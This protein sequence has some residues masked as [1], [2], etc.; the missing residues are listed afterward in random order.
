MS[1]P[2]PEELLA[3]AAE[4]ATAAATLLAQEGAQQRPEVADT[5]P[6]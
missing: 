2:D 4:T 5:S 3:L 1:A 6:A